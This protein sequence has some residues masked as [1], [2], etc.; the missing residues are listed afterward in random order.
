MKDFR[1]I[2]SNKV[3]LT[4]SKLESK[5]YDDLYKQLLVYKTVKVTFMS[6]FNVQFYSLILKRLIGLR[7]RRWHSCQGQTYCTIFGRIG[8]TLN[9]HPSGSYPRML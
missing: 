6:E 4:F 3:M 9:L 5:L 8:C 1:L 2:I 7:N